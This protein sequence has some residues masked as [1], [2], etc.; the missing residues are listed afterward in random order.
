M[1][2]FNNVAINEYERVDDLHRKGY[3]IIQDPKKFCFGIDAVLLSDF[4]KVKKNE[5]VID[6]GTGTGVIPILLEGRYGGE[7]YFAIDIQK[8]S[9]EMAQRSVKLNSLENKINISLCDIK[10]VYNHFDNASFDVVTSNPPYMST[11]GGIVNDYDAKAI[12][13]HEILCNLEDVIF[14]AAKLLKFGGRFYMIHRPHR[15]VD[16]FVLLRKYK[17]EPKSIRFIHS[18]A[19]KEPSMVLIESNRGGKPMLKVL[20]PLVVYKNSKEYTDEIYKIYYE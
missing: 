13:R 6:L 17:L 20:S 2:F 4:A 1:D 14:A 12:A 8:D 3:F 10:D 9:V 18:Y 5:K 19:D 11:G 7:N 16:V 15:L